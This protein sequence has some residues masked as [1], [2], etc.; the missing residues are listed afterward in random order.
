MHLNS[1]V[2]VSLEVLQADHVNEVYDGSKTHNIKYCYY[3]G[4]RVLWTPYILVDD[5]KIDIGYSN[6]RWQNE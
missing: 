6:E 5:W 3:W 2:V 1:K 4:Q